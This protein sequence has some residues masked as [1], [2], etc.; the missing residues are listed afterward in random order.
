MGTWRTP[1][2]QLRQGYHA[3][4]AASCIALPG[5]GGNAA[6]AVGGASAD[7]QAVSHTAISPQAPVAEA[8]PLPASTAPEALA[9]GGSGSSS[10]Q[11]GVSSASVASVS[12]DCS[13]FAASLLGN[14]V[15]MDFRNDTAQT[16]YLASTNAHCGAWPAFVEFS[17]NAA[18]VELYV[19]DC[20]PDCGRLI[21]SGY[22][23]EGVNTA[24]G[25]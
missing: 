19:G 15:S 3:L 18:P 6:D 11:G 13:S 2:M 14:F 1:L 4:A 12:S 16:I 8:I 20:L 10:G 17:Q 7:Q 21:E 22:R 5:C 9:C 25:C 24:G 23:G